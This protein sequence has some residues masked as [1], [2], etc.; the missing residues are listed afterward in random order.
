VYFLFDGQSP[1]DRPFSRVPGSDPELY[2]VVTGAWFPSDQS[3]HLIVRAYDSAGQAGEAS[4]T[5]TLVRPPIGDIEVTKLEMTQATQCLNNPTCPDN[6]V[7][8]YTNKP[9]LVRAYVR[10]TTAPAPAVPVYGRICLDRTGAC[11]P[12]L[13]A[14]RLTTDEPVAARRPH[15]RGTLNFLLPAA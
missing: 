13:E 9:T 12:S 15:I 8:L 2:E 10:M 7:T 3:Q 6:S 5:F 11:V 4:V 1:R 14:W